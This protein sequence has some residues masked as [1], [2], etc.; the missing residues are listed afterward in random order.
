[1]LVGGLTGRFFTISAEKGM[2]LALRTQTNHSCLLLVDA[3]GVLEA[4]HGFFHDWSNGVTIIIMKVSSTFA[5][6]LL[7]VFF[8]LVGGQRYVSGNG[9]RGWFVLIR[10][11]FVLSVRDF[12]FTFLASCDHAGHFFEELFDVVACFGGDFHV[13]ES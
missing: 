12:F 7:A 4:L 6:L 8:G 3:L 1:M 13:S 9:S 10:L 11:S 2:G 5:L